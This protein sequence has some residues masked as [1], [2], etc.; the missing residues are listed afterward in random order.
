MTG[1]STAEHDTDTDSAE[2][3]APDPLTRAYRHD[4]HK[5]FG[6]SHILAGE[7]YG[8]IRIN[9]QVPLGA[10]ADAAM[11]SRPAAS[12]DQTVSN[13]CTPHRLSLLTGS[14][15]PESSNCRS[16]CQGWRS[17]S[18]TC[19]RHRTPSNSTPNG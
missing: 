2:S 4:T 12:P 1:E 10:D 18:S 6:R 13:H 15:H 16:S 7:W 5:L 8:D 11:L 3:T 19:S 14:H 17:T 9:E